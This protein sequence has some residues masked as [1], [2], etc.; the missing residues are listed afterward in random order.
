MEDLVEAGVNIT[1][2]GGLKLEPEGLNGVGV[3]TRLWAAA[4]G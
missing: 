3:V 4:R 1:S 2:D